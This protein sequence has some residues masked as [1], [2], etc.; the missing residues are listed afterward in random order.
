MHRRSLDVYDLSY[1]TE[2]VIR[3][4][5][6]PGYY[7]V[8]IGHVGRAVFT[9]EGRTVRFSPTI[10]NPGQVV[11]ARWGAT[12][13]ARIMRVPT[14]M[15]ED[16][17]RAELG[18]TPRT[19]IRFETAL[20]PRIPH[21]AE[22]VDLAA[23]F[24]A[25]ADSGFLA[26]SPLAAAHFEQL[27][28]LTMVHLTRSATSAKSASQEH[29]PTSSQS[30][31]ATLRNVPWATS[32][33]TGDSPTPAVSPPPTTPCTAGSP[34]KPS[35]SARSSAR[36]RSSSAVIG[37]VGRVVVAGRAAWVGASAAADAPFAADARLRSGRWAVGRS[38]LRVS[39]LRRRRQEWLP[40]SMA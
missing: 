21:V 1:G 13:T 15:V 32:P 4:V 24:S 16:A 20:D 8:R 6:P 33:G 27:V 7:A 38:G 3:P 12:A 10:V 11:T 26:N 23:R 40:C 17:I 14:V 35:A 37:G 19:P 36:G 34:A 22:W 5:R 9:S 25:M 2:V 18:E 31:K 39:A 30:L 29:T 28:V